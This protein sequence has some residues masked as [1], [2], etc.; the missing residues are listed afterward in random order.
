MFLPSKHLLRAFYETL[1]SKNPSKNLIFTEEPLQAPSQNPSKKHLLLKS[2][3][4]TLRRVAC[5]CMT[6]L[7][8]TLLRVFGVFGRVFVPADPP[9]RG[10]LEALRAKKKTSFRNARLFVILFVRNFWRVYSQFLRSV[11]NSVCGPFNRNSR[12]NPSFSW[13]GGG[14]KGRKNCEQKF[15][16]QTGVS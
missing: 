5:G 1:P 14:V 6:P 15:C 9:K 12:G 11:R 10:L 16:E 2:L 3:L 13:L 4:R 7:V 8:C